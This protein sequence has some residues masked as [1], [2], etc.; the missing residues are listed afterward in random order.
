M[1]RILQKD[2]SI[3]ISEARKIV[4]LRNRVIHGYDSVSDATI[5]SIVIK[6][7]PRLKV[8]V[9]QLLKE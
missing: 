9:K 8:E 2:S 7:I 4:D 3:T 6:H 5:W 1:N